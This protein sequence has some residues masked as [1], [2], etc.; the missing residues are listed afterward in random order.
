MS[1]TPLPYDQCRKVFAS[2]VGVR[3]AGANPQDYR[4]DI[5]QRFGLTA[6]HLAVIEQKGDANGWGRRPPG[7]LGHI[8][9]GSRGVPLTVNCPSRPTRT[10]SPGDRVP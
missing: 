10:R 2:I 9:F 4:K 5:A 3:A 1:D 7:R 6:K 8:G